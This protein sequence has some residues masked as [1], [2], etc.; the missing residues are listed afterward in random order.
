M[1]DI[2][3]TEY[4]TE[5]PETGLSSSNSTLDTEQAKQTG[6]ETL[7]TGRGEQARQEREP[8]VNPLTETDPDVHEV[9]TRR[10][11]PVQ[12]EHAIDRTAAVS[13]ELTEPALRLAIR[14]SDIASRF[15]EWLTT[16]GFG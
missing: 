9:G 3:T 14:T 7:E 11:E 2:E 5:E 16:E 1:V 12:T 13:A 8:D 4:V 6:H 10:H 15:V